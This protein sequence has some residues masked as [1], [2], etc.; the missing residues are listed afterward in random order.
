MKDT[1]Q[2]L[3]DNAV[4]LFSSKSYNGVGVQEICNHTG[5]TK[6]T[7]YHHYDSKRELT[8]D[9]ID[10]MWRSY[11]EEML[12]PVFDSELDVLQKFKELLLAF[13]N[14]HFA[15]KNENGNVIGCRL[16]N[17]ALEL[18][19]QDE[20]IR[21][22]LEE[23]FMKW[24]GYFGRVLSEAVH[25][26]QLPN[27]TNIEATAKAMLAYIEGLALFGKTFNEPDFLSDLSNGIMKLV[28]KKEEV[29]R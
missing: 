8:I 19:T 11:E 24:F 7:F 10:S 26:G 4:D 12:N 22:K 21:N 9:A 6:G 28:I 3:I 20:Q 18:S 16:G 27:D 5:I 14:Y 17:L 2:L 1:K 15:A 29:K 23:I 25:Q 13:Y